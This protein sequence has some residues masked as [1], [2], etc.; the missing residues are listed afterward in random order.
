MDAFDLVVI[1]ADIICFRSAVAHE[2]RYITCESGVPQCCGE[3]DTRTDYK[4]A[5]K[6]LGLEAEY[7]NSVI[8]DHQRLQPNALR[9]TEYSIKNTIESIRK[10]VNAKQVKLVLG[11]KGNFRRELPL[12]VRYKWSRDTSIRPLLLRHA[13]KYILKHY[14]VE[15]SEGEEADDLISKYQYQ[16]FLNKGSIVVETCDKDA[17]STAGYVYNH[18]REELVYIPNALGELYLEKGK[19]TG[20]GRRWLYAQILLGDSADDYKPTDLYSMITGN[21]GNYADTGVYNTLKDCKTDK[22]CWE[23][24]VVKYQ[25]WYG[26]IEGWHSWEGVPQEGTW[27]DLLQLYVDCPFMRRV[28][29]ERLDVRAVL[30][31]LNIEW[32]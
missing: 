21:K 12:P 9:F 16:G 4:K 27:L 31:K 5:L 3:W 25:E 7:A 10:A 29:N 24:I 28:D 19:L 22:E 2:E 32:G 23:A 1:D 17:N 11:G 15:L 8:T 14:D 6:E 26:E 20:I 18:V 13:Q 30:T